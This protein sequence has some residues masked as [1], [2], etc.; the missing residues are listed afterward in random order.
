MKD[1][2]IQCPLCQNEIPFDQTQCAYCGAL[3]T[4]GPS[5]GTPILK[6]VICLK[7]GEK[8]YSYDECAHC[9][10]PFTKACPSCGADMKLND[11]QCPKCGLS[12]RKFSAARRRVDI[13]SARRRVKLPVNLGE[14]WTYI[15]PIGIAVLVAICAALFALCTPREKAKAVGAPKAG[16]MRG[17]DT[18]GD[19]KAEHWDIYGESGK[20][21]ERRFDENHDGKIERIEFYDE[22]GVIRRAQVDEN[23]DGKYE[24]L[25]AYGPTGKLRIAYYYLGADPQRPTK[26]EMFSVDGKLVEQWIDNNGDYIF[27]QYNRWDA[28]QHLLIAGA[29]TKKQGFI[30]LYVVYRGS[31]KVFQ[32]WYDLNGDGVIEKIETYNV[33]GV[34]VIIEED[35]NGDGLIDKKAFYDATGTLRWEQFDTDG[36]G[37]FDTFKSYTET[38]KF[39]RTGVDTNGDSRPDS[40]Q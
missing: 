16:Q 20:V 6:G 28:H 3:L 37:I 22:T 40:W 7:C 29:D 34:R 9:G 32:R 12:V 30:D 8:N 38:G 4:P 10:H 21:I 24:K 33:D 15:V 13:A 19:G 18:N 36:D 31:K 2:L 25:E 39:A 26:L 35:T 27:D 5:R 14:K 17:V 1:H 11:L 23:G